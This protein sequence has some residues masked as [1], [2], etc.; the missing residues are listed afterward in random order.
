MTPDIKCFLLEDLR[1]S[2]YCLRRYV[3]S[4]KAKCSRPDGYH[5]AHS[6]PIADRPDPDFKRGDKYYGVCGMN[7]PE[8]NHADPRWPK[9]CACGYAFTE[10]DPWQ[11]SAGGLYRR[12]DNGE[13]VTW[14]DAPAGSVAE[15]K[16][17]K[18]NEWMVRLPDGSDFITCQRATNCRC[19]K[20]KPEHRCW[21]TT[22][23]PPNITVTPSIQ[24][25][26]WHGFL[27]NGVLRS[28]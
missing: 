2:R 1:T 22:G 10:D 3:S 26:R 7:P 17:W 21:T 16:W 11:I 14:R 6:D 24:T 19:P 12:K 15:A 28:C 13:I 8:I 25:G 27:T 5:N 9:A 18:E 4:D 20:D 23:T